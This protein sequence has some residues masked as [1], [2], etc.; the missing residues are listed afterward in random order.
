MNRAQQKPSTRNVL[1]ML[2]KRNG[3]MSA[4][5]LAE[6][7]G[8]TEMGVRR[9]LHQG[10]EENV[11]E[12]VQVKQPMGR[13]LQLYRIS[14]QGDEQFPKQY[15]QLLLDLLHEVES[16]DSGSDNSVQQ[17]FEGRRRSLKRKYESSMLGKTF[18]ERVQQLSSIQDAG[19]Y[20]V[21]TEQLSDEEWLLHE[22]N[23]PIAQVAQAY[24]YPCH[25]E[26]ELFRELLGADVERLECLAKQGSRCTYRI[27]KSQS[28]LDS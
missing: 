22:Y 10:I 5:Q 20:M 21:E 7:L 11:L 14:A 9:H 12:T 27:R 4:A 18:G 26:L 2:L 23:C 1:L 25:C 24:E 16:N 19:G 8:L 15:H 17:L 3:P 13:P 6:R 28:S